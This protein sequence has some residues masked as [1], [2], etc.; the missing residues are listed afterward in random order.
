MAKIAFMIP[1]TRLVRVE[2]QKRGS[3]QT[4]Y[5]AIIPRPKD[6]ETLF[7]VMRETRKVGPSQ[8]RDV[9][10]VNELVPRN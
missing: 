4:K 2:Y 8:I 5:A 9:K 3:N 1:T 6:C 7:T 10:P